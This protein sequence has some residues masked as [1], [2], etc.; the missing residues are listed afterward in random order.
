M[1]HLRWLVSGLLPPLVGGILIF[2]AYD[3]GPATDAAHGVTPQLDLIEITAQALPELPPE[4]HR[5]PLGQ[6]VEFVVRRNDTLERIFRQLKLSLSDLAS[7]RDLPDARASLDFLRPGDLIT[8]VHADGLVQ[9]LNRRI[10]DTQTLEIMREADGFSA[11]VIE[12]PL[13]IR[14]VERHG[15]IDTSLFNAARAVGVGSGVIMQ[16]ANDIFGWDI[17]FALEIRPGDEFTVIYEQRYRDGKLIGDG[18]VLAAEFVNAGHAYRAVRFE[19][20]DGEV[21]DY[22]TP[23]GRSMRKQF[24]RAPVDFT[25][26]SSNFNPRRLHPILNRIRAHQGVDYAAPNGTPIKA[27][28]DGKVEF[29]GWKGGYG[30]AVILQHGGG[31]TTLYGHMSGFARGLRTGQRV[32]QGQIIGYVGHSGA[33]TG[34]H[35]HYEYRINGVHK[36]PRTVPLP[37]AKPIPPSYMAAFQQSAD[38]LLT[39]L[40]RSRATVVAAAE[41]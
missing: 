22:F 31:V 30:R 24:L 20:E 5:Q 3:S 34:P 8:L 12:T 25:R 1:D 33:A 11:Q 36:N 41:R 17:D 23:E 9:A 37:N 21:A 10:S 6:T 14:T 39:E 16:L 19:S 18:N 28:G 26:I 40:D 32:R 35:L 2:N 15:H 27:A 38:R 7:I 4:T 29:E 13:E